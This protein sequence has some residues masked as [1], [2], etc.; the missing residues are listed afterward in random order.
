MVDTTNYMGGLWSVQ[1]R[2]DVT[3]LSR[4]AMDLGLKKKDLRAFGFRVPLKKQKKEKKGACLG[5]AKV[6]V[7]YLDSDLCITTT[8]QGMDGPLLVYTKGNFWTARRKVSACSVHLWHGW[9]CYFRLQ[10][11]SIAFAYYL[12]T[13]FT[14]NTQ[15]RFLL[16]T[17]R[18]MWSNQSPLQLRQ[19]VVSALPFL[20]RS[21]SDSQQPDVLLPGGPPVY[22]DEENKVML[23]RTYADK[24]RLTVLKMGE[25][26]IN[27]DGTLREDLTAA[28]DGESDPFVHLDPIERQELMKSMTI[29]AIEAAGKE[30]RDA[31]KRKGKR[32]RQTPIDRSF[33]KL[34]KEPAER[35]FKKPQDES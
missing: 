27:P 22:S 31:N 35:A 13:P 30:Q 11:Y 34:K 25:P 8:E 2:Y 29:E 21:S 23:E 5:N 14:V 7:I 17:A 10:T 3:G 18:W 4:T 26:L 6:Q 33:K 15:S 16:A 9:R 1:R 20:R 32:Y 19:K 12:P 24:S 28:W